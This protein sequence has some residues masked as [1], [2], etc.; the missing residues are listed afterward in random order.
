MTVNEEWGDR[1]L[2][3]A[4]GDLVVDA[5]STVGREDDGRRHIAADLYTVRLAGARVGYDLMECSRE[6]R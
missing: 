1:R 2:A 6:R 3:R 4:E 5:S